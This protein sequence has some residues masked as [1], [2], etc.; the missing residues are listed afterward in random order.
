MTTL[1]TGP[2]TLLPSD[3]GVMAVL[4]NQGKHVAN[5]RIV[6]DLPRER[7]LEAGAAI[8]SKP[9]D[10]LRAVIGEFLEWYEGP[11]ENGESF[12]YWCAR[13]GADTIQIVCEFAERIAK[14]Y[15]G[16]QADPVRDVAPVLFG[17]VQ[18][19]VECAELNQDSIEAETEEL[20]DRAGAL[21]N[22]FPQAEGCTP[23][24]PVR[25]AAPDMLAVLKALSEWAREHTSPRDANSPHDLLVTAEAAIA[26]A[27]G[28]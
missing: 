2:F 6:A 24:D 19:F 3:N 11:E 16:G 1:P 10:A 20:L 7:H 23:P 8:V 17:L 5:L 27:E 21:L 18:E 26:K 13:S 4:D 28:R 22:R 12:A 25:A 9:G 15:R 14:A